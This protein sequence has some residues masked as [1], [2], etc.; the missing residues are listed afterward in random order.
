MKRGPAETTEPVLTEY[1]SVT[2]DRRDR[3]RSDTIR[4][5]EMSWDNRTTAQVA[6]NLNTFLA[7]TGVPLKVVAAE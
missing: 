4:K 5:V 6:E 7:A 1:W 2:Y 3:D